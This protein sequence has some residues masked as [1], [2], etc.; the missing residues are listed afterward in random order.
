MTK[1][2]NRALGWLAV[3]L[4]AFAAP[5]LAGQPE[6]AGK[7]P[8]K[9][10]ASAERK[11]PTAEQRVKM[12]EHHERIAACLR[13][14]R[15]I[16]ECRA[17]MRTMHEEMRKQCKEAGGGECPMGYPGHQRGHHGDH[18]G[19]KGKGMGGPATGDTSTTE[20]APA[21]TN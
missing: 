20:T 11:P 9:G 18:H 12:A 10:P 4:L 17:E 8:G 1:R 2:T 3:A 7:G 16:E 13:S 19:G 6:G 21:P 14:T 5:A 15:P